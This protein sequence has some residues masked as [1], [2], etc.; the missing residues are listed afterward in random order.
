MQVCKIAHYF[1]SL[2][3]QNFIF[4]F[5]IHIIRPHHST[6]YVDAVYCYRPSS[7]VCL[8]VCL[9]VT[10]VSSAKMPELIEESSGRRKPRIRWGWSRSPW[11][12]A[13]LMGGKGIPL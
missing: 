8:L 11:K 9:S 13:I 1:E 12:G 6:T 3:K 2:P 7:M 10:V 5:M 4:L